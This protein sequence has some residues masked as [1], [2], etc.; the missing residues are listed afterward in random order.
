MIEA[1]VTAAGGAFAA[2]V[3]TKG[4][5]TCRRA[6]SAFDPLSCCLAIPATRLQAGCSS[7]T[8]VD[9]LVSFDTR[10]D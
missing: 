10:K 2:L 7:P 1:A 3:P 9:Q 6:Q 8:G 4:P 5:P